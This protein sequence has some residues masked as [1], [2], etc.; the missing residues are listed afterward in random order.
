[1]QAENQRSWLRNF[2]MRGFHLLVT[3][4]V[5]GA[6]QDT[7]CGFKVANFFPGTVPT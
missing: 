6:V 5:G 2:L 3:L 7:Q 1:M 4:I